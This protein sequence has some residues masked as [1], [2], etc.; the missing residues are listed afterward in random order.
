METQLA[1]VRAGLGVAVA[2]RSYAA[3]MPELCVLA[4]AELPPLPPLEVYVVTRA[5]IR[6]V[7][8]VA[9]VYEALVSGLRTLEAE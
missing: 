3:V 7:P 1:L 6:R 4:V 8:R 2:P 9:A 5:A